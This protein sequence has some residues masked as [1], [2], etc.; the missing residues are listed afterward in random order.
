MH[1]G[2]K[3]DRAV[4]KLK[5]ARKDSTGKSAAKEMLDLDYNCKLVHDTGL[6]KFEATDKDGNLKH[7]KL[8]TLTDGDSSQC[9]GGQCCSLNYVGDKEASAKLGISYVCQ[10]TYGWARYDESHNYNNQAVAGSKTAGL[11][12]RLSLK[13]DSSFAYEFMIF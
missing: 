3:Q 6:V 5:N 13:L 4:K 1:K 11:W 10:I 9:V 8:D 2:D 7:T 12:G